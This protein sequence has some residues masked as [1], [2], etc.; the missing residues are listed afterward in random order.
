MGDAKRTIQACQETRAKYKE[1]V[2]PL[3]E[4]IKEKREELKI[5]FSD[6]PKKFREKSK[7]KIKKLKQKWTKENKDLMDK[8]K[9]LYK[10][11]K[12]D[13]AKFQNLVKDAQNLNSELDEKTLREMIM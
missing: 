12:V 2:E 9:A 11:K 7:R 4:K 8:Y 13:E 1:K 5:V 10:Q 6:D 3:I